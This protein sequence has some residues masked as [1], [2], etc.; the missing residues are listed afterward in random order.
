MRKSATIQR[1]RRLLNEHVRNVAP[2]GST[3]NS[4]HHTSPIICNSLAQTARTHPRDDRAPLG[5]RTHGKMDRFL[6][7][8]IAEAHG[9]EVHLT[10]H[11]R[12]LSR[13]G[14]SKARSET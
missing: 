13:E 1:Q 4:S 6:E 14:S 9:R 7:E 12:P 5:R 10:S 3:V 2:P 8:V 11:P